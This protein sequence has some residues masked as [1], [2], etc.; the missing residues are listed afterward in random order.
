MDLRRLDVGGPAPKSVMLPA[1][2]YFAYMKA[3]G[4][5][6]V[7]R[8]KLQALE[9]SHESAVLVVASSDGSVHSLPQDEDA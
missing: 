4:K 2:A 3:A 9:L 5:A 6:D 7:A 1:S 8:R